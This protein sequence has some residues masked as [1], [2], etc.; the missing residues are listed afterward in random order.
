[1]FSK[2]L[3]PSRREIAWCALIS[4]WSIA[5]SAPA[6]AQ[7]PSPVT[8]EQL[9]AG[10][11]R[12]CRSSF[13]DSAAFDAAIAAATEFNKVSRPSLFSGVELNRRWRA[14]GM[15]L[16][17]TN[18]PGPLHPQCAVTGT[19]AADLDPDAVAAMLARRLA[20]ISDQRDPSGY[21]QW[22]FRDE[23]A[24]YWVYFN[25]RPLPRG[26]PDVELLL[27]PNPTGERG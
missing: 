4:V 2:I 27:H 21:R 1:M 3:I 20:L 19:A 23:S 14:D 25:L 24:G 5:L 6:R 26:Q 22:T 11:E 10:F 7:P 13:A 15:T 18:A 9:L 16:S 17:Y 12:F 8:A